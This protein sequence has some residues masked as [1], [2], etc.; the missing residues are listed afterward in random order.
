MIHSTK[1][2]RTLALYVNTRG[3]A[4]A[5]F[6]APLSLEDWGVKVT[7]GT[8]RHADGL[9]AVRQLVEKYR[10]EALVI[11]DVR[12]RSSRR[13]QHIRT[14]Y[15]AIARYAERERIAIVS[16]SRRAIH[17]AFAVAG[18]SN[19]KHDMNCVIVRMIPV[20]AVRQPPKRKPWIAEPLAQAF[21]DAVSLGMTFFATT[22]RLDIVQAMDGEDEA[23]LAVCCERTPYLISSAL[24]T[25][26]LRTAE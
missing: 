3:I 2:P 20:L 14:L 8:S 17:E 7:L 6:T 16:Y 1:C 26:Q 13:H 22:K 5:L 9:R 19:N 12:E 11:E 10:P 25:L 23:P 4:F 15:R 18:A 21:F 24:P